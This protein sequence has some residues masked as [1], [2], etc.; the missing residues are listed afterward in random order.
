[1]KPPL[2]L[3]DPSLQACQD[4]CLDAKKTRDKYGITK[5][6]F[7]I[8]SIVFAG[9]AITICIYIFNSG[10]S[11]DF[12][13]GAKAM[14]LFT[15]SYKFLQ[16]YRRSEVDYRY[17][18]SIYQDWKKRRIKLGIL[19][20]NLENIQAGHAIIDVLFANEEG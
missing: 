1:M 18:N 10:K 15:I 9:I 13:T 4:A 7:L 19:N 8:V 20:N 3:K 12:F 6:A 5:L 16:Q 14:C 17:Y 11:F 2:K